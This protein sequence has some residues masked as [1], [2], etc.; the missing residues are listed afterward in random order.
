MSQGCS[1]DACTDKAC[2]R[3][4]T[5]S[6]AMSCW[7]D[8]VVKASSQL[9]W[10]LIACWDPKL[11]PNSQSQILELQAEIPRS[12]IHILYPFSGIKTWWM[13][14]LF[15]FWKSRTLFHELTA[16]DSGLFCLA[17]T[18]DCDGSQGFIP[19]PNPLFNWCR[20]LFCCIQ[21]DLWLIMAYSLE[22][23]A[24]MTISWE[25]N[26]GGSGNFR[27]WPWII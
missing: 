22:W 24:K 4:V 23:V 25:H 5:F 17:K 7:S 27:W 20:Q 19:V 15:S 16:I 13:S 10:L 2:P 8:W 21:S 26:G 3:D 11:D 14:K 9:P 1:I 18:T 12:A 6:Q